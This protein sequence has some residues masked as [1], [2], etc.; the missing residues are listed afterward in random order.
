MEWQPKFERLI[1]TELAREL[2][3]G[4]WSANT[5]TYNNR[6]VKLYLETI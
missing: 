1:I 6:A 4:G 2:G 5:T 3:G